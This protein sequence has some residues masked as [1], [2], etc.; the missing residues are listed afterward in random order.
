MPRG[1]ENIR[2]YVTY[3]RGAGVVRRVRRRVLKRRLALV[4]HRTIRRVLI[5]ELMD[6]IA[7]DMVGADSGVELLG[8]WTILPL[9]RHETI[10]VT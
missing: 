6:S 1:Y 10:I 7:A 8:C 9:R 4:P 2:F 3:K 5:L